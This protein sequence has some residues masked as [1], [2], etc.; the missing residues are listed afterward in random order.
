MI[1]NIQIS[2]DHD[3]TFNEASSVKTDLIVALEK[4]QNWKKKSRERSLAIT[5]IQEAIFWLQNDM[6]NEPVEQIP[7][8]QI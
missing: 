7:V 6:A 5:K 8:E 2:E 4:A 1:Q 3:S